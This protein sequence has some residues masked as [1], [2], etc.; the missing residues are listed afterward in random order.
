MYKLFVAVGIGILWAPAAFAQFSQFVT[1]NEQVMLQPEFPQPGETV[2]ATIESYGANIA[3]ASLLWRVNGEVIGDAANRRST[4]FTTGSLGSTDNVEVVIT[5]PDGSIRT[6][7]KQ[8]VPLYLD[9]VIEPQTHVPDFYQGRAH[10]SVG[11]TV[12]ATA[13]LTGASTPPSG[14]VYTWRLNQRVLEGGSIRGQNKVLFTTPAGRDMILSLQVSQL[15][16]EV[17]ASRTIIV[18]IVKPEIHFYESNSLYGLIPRSITDTLTM[19]TGTVTIQAEPYHLNSLTFNDPP[20]LSWKIGAVEA[21]IM[22]NPYQVTLERT[23]TSG[24]ATLKFDVRDDTEL[25]QG[26]RGT[27]N[28]RY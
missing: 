3:G 20:L 1:Q 25:L 2:T 26:A 15:N 16:G 12:Q 8:V 6:V 13:L 10:P 4:T 28:V 11:S 14:L 9:I 24:G 19:I 27:M 17:V 5:N 23:G 18:P 7:T 21:P 22:N